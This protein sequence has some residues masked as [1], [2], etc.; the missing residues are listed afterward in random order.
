MTRHWIARRT[1]PASLVIALVAVAASSVASIGPAGAGAA[2]ASRPAQ[3]TAVHAQAAVP[4]QVSRLLKA[5]QNCSVV[6]AWPS[7]VGGGTD[8]AVGAR[9]DRD[10]ATT[11][12]GAGRRLRSCIGSAA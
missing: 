1:G 9:D 4:G 7:R 11:L 5:N 6:Q 10:S 2:G 3:L 12:K 8:A